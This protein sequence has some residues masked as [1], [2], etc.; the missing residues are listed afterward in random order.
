MNYF[1]NPYII[2]AIRVIRGSK[3]ELPG[4]NVADAFVFHV[5]HEGIVEGH[6]KFFVSVELQPP[7]DGEMVVVVTESAEGDLAAQ[8][9]A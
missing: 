6:G 5:I 7:A 1:I 4:E 9:R 8:F 2:R 3:K